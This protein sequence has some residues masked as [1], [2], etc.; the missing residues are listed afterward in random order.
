MRIIAVVTS[1]FLG[2]FVAA[3][4]GLSLAAASKVERIFEFRVFVVYRAQPLAV[5]TFA[6]LFGKVG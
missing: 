2:L 3:A 6:S 5:L 4:V 1:S